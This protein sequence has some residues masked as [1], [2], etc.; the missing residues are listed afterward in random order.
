MTLSGQSY[1]VPTTSQSTRRSWYAIQVRWHTS[2]VPLLFQ[3]TPEPTPPPEPTGPSPPP[4]PE[5]PILPKE[6]EE[7][8]L[9]EPGLS[10]GA[11][12]GIGAGIGIGALA[13]IAF[14][15]FFLWRRKKNQAAGPIY[16]AANAAGSD[17]PEVV[18]YSVNAEQKE[19]NHTT[20]PYASD[21]LGST[22]G[23]QPPTPYAA[24]KM[25]PSSPGS[26]HTP[27]Q[28]SPL[29]ELGSHASSPVTQP[30][31]G[32]FNAGANDRW[33]NMEVAPA[34]GLEVVPQDPRDLERA[35]IQEDLA[36]IEARR[37]RLHEMHILETEEEQLR[38]RLQQLT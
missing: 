24:A 23:S 6:E 38:R 9:E 7:Q 36:R 4:A 35:R 25:I 19:P 2:D 26:M 10:T 31:G 11:K 32:F 8:P 15:M 20:V 16:H 5:P 33:S 22:Y 34:E 29:P 28:A 1:C 37:Q 13:T 30:V 12:A 18:T 14:L 3:T 21:Q 27:P 17:A